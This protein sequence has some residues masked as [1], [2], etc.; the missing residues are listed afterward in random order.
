MSTLFDFLSI[1]IGLVFIYWLLS[2]LTSYGM[3]MIASFFKLRAHNLADA[4]HL[5]LDPTTDKLKGAAEIKK[6]WLDGREIWDNGVVKEAGA[7]LQSVMAKKMNENLVK[8]FY[9]HPMIATLSKPNHLPSYINPA[10]FSSTLIDL[11][12]RSGSAAVNTPDEYL[13]SVITGVQQMND[14]ALKSAIMPLIEDAENVETDAAKRI[15]LVKSKLEDW[16]N[17]TMDR[18]SGWYKRKLTWISIILGMLI[19]F[20]LNA[21]SIGIAQALWR[22]GVLRQSIATA[23]GPV[24][25]DALTNKQPTPDQA[26]TKL[27][28][29]SF[30]LGWNGQLASNAPGSVPAPQD[31]P[32]KLVDIIIKLVGLAITGLSISQGSSIWFDALQKLINLSSSGTKPKS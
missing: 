27:N 1:V 6:T 31:I 15:T 19:A 26:L 2:I 8:T 22:D 11:F 16:F 14:D 32:V 7:S 24:F 21:D 3:E 4:I 17:A 5:M 23:A 18:S 13:E 30:P 25:Q 12:A 20:G 29:L 28:A 10:V 9:S